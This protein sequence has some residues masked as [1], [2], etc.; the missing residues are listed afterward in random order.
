[1][2]VDRANRDRLVD[3][4]DRYLSDETTAFEFDEC[5]FGIRGETN[6]PTVRHVV[7]ALW[8]HYDDCDD[9]KVVL[10]KAEWDYFQRLR[11]LLESDA[12]LEVRKHHLWSWTQL[13]AAAA[14]AGFAWWAIR[15]GY[16]S[17]LF[18]VAMP[19]GVVAIVISRWRRRVL[20]GQARADVALAPFSSVSQLRSIRRGVRGF[21]K[22]RYRDDLA[23]RTIRRQIGP[24]VSMLQTYSIWLLVSPVVLLTQLLPLRWETLHVVSSLPS[25]LGTLAAAG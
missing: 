1:M 2:D 19:F 18:I 8:C 13:V 23:T 5:I 24:F 15:W 14:L 16:G 6:D 4:I 22:R 10:T 17:Q 12:S 7:D 21:H 9:H 25:E 3:A 20:Q 11:L